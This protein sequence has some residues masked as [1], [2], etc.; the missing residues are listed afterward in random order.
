MLVNRRNSGGSLKKGINR[1]IAQYSSLFVFMYWNLDVI[2]TL[3]F[4]FILKNIRVEIFIKLCRNRSPKRSLKRSWKISLKRK[5]SRRKNLLRS[6][7]LL[8]WCCQ[9]LSHLVSIF[10]KSVPIE[11]T[12]L[13]EKLEI[14][15]GATTPR[16]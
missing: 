2:Y 8:K 15:R 13:L 6:P 12:P 10:F 11:N 3:I 1:S 4:V 7:A 5:G 9:K 16:F 14:G